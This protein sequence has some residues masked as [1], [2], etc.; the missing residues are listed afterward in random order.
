LETHSYCRCEKERENNAAA[1]ICT[2]LR[3]YTWYI[4]EINKDY[5]YNVITV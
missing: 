2:K 4:G 1:M 5:N 3:V